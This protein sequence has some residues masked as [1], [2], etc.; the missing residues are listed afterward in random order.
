VLGERDIGGQ[1]IKLVTRTDIR[2]AQ[3]NVS[4][5]P[6]LH[7]LSLAPLRRPSTQLTVF[8]KSTE[9]SDVLPLASVAVALITPIPLIGV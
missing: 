6:P 4:L 7:P 2:S 1:N 3:A 8:W 5:T 9:N